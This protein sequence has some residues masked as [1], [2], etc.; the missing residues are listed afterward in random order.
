MTCYKCVGGIHI[1]YDKTEPQVL[2]GTTVGVYFRKTS[3]RTRTGL[4]VGAGR[5]W[6]NVVYYLPTIFRRTLADRLKTP[7]VSWL[8]TSI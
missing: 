1:K 7:H 2:R 5:L 4:M 8:D 6:A 3:T